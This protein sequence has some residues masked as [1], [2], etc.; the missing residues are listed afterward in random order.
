M[1]VGSRKC[2]AAGERAISNGVISL[3]IGD[4]RALVAVELLGSA[5][6]ERHGH[7]VVPPSAVGRQPVH[8]IDGLPGIALAVVEL[9]RVDAAELAVESKTDA[10]RYIIGDVP[11]AL[12]RVLRTN[13]PHAAMTFSTD[14]SSIAP[15]ARRPSPPG[16][17]RASTAIL[18]ALSRGSPGDCLI[19]AVLPMLPWDQS[20]HQTRGDS[21]PI[22]Y[23]TIMNPVALAAGGPNC[24][25][26]VR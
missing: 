8:E 18:V 21:P 11:A 14:G 10:G 16:T 3:S 22:E 6:D 7:D 19:A 24:H 9:E 23:E 26:N 15:S 1:R 13:P 12:R 2:G 20:L 5:F 25:L 17:S 4:H